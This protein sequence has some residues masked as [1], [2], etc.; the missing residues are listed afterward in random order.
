[1]TAAVYTNELEQQFSRLPGFM[2]SVLRDPFNWVDGVLKDIAGQPDQLVSA[3][4]AYAALGRQIG[5]LGAEQEQDRTAILGGA[6]AG[7]SYEAF[8]AKMAEVER[9]ISALGLATGQT[10]QLLDSAAQACAQSASM[11]VYI[12]EGTISF[13]LQ[14]AVVSGVLSLFTFG[15]A[16]AAGAAAAVAKFASACDRI[17]GIIAKL[18]SVLEKIAS[19]LEKLAGICATVKTY[20]MTLQDQIKEAKGIK[21]LITKAKMQRSG[22][23][24]AVRTTAGY[25]VDGG[26]IPGP[27]GGGLHA[28]ASGYQGGKDVHDA[29]P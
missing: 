6:Y 16:A 20:L 5:Q 21:N 14:D 22:I 24:L 29:A 3:G 12:V 19:L 17:G 9:Q 27:V 18:T 23:N 28:G 7:A 8:S 13:I 10:Q 15:A 2:Q 1:M 4:N 25:G 11:I 26:A